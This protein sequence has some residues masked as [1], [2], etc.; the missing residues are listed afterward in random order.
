M[1]GL[2]GRLEKPLE[3][4]RQW[5]HR[6]LVTSH[7]G[8]DMSHA[9]A[10]CPPAVAIIAPLV[11][12]F[13][14]LLGALCG[15]VGWCLLIAAPCCLPACLRRVKHVHLIVGGALG[16]DPARLL[17]C[18]PE[19]V[20]MSALPRALC[21]ALEQRARAAL[22]SSMVNVRPAAPTCSRHDGA[23]DEKLVGSDGA[24]LIMDGVMMGLGRLVLV[25]AVLGVVSYQRQ[26]AHSAC[27][28]MAMA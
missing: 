3:V 27:C 6:T 28:T 17:K 9:G 16:G 1:C 25:L 7:G 26:G 13:D 24:S 23:W 11:A 21:T 12:A 22:V 2:G 14:D 5:P 10:A 4:V 20:A 15:D 18:V 8:Q 19:E